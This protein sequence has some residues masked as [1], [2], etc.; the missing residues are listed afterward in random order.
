MV[1]A[2]RIEHKGEDGLFKYEAVVPSKS[3]AS[4]MEIYSELKSGTT[5]AQV[6]SRDYPIDR[7]KVEEA[8]RQAGFGETELS[9]VGEC[10]KEYENTVGV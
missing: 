7:G 1:Q 4:A 2:Y 5:T 6:V 3:I 8:L 9:I 10:L